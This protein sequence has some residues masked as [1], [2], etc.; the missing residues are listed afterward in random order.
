MP[1]HKQQQQSSSSRPSVLVMMAATVLLTTLSSFS[2]TV[3]AFNT[4]TTKAAR[5]VSRL[6]SSSSSSAVDINSCISRISTLQQLLQMHG[7]PGSATC[8]QAND[9]IPII[10]PIQEAP[11]LV[12]SLTSSQDDELSNIHPYLFPIAKSKSTGNVICAMKS[13]YSDNTDKEMP[14]PIV[15]TSIG[16][17][18]MNLLALNSEHLMRRIACEQDFAG[19][20]AET[21]AL[22]NDGLG[23]GLLKEKAFDNPY[24]VG[25]V[26][27][28]G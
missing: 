9:L 6:F 25:D 12:A 2:V 17:R 5:S 1:Y 21:V 11:E 24:V 10:E 28:L 4:G 8:N 23:A 19:N 20:G 7:A 14:W 13:A 26:E 22:Y 3:V 16:G 15:E 18:G 27:K